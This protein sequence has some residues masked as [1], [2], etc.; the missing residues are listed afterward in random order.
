[1]TDH[2]HSSIVAFSLKIAV[3]QAG[4]HPGM[5]SNQAGV[6]GKTPTSLYSVGMH[7]ENASLLPQVP[8]FI[9][10]FHASS[11]RAVIA[12]EA[13]GLAVMRETHRNVTNPGSRNLPFTWAELHNC[14]CCCAGL[15][16][17]LINETKC[18][19]HS[20]A[21]LRTKDGHSLARS[22]FG[23]WAV[24]Q[25]IDNHRTQNPLRLENFPPIS[26]Q[27]LMLKGNTDPTGFKGVCHPLGVGRI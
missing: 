6:V 23:R 10:P 9:D 16:E 17:S 20:C 25:P 18:G 24:S 7:Y 26:A 3:K 22:L 19:C 14:S 8:E 1:M 5:S 12:T 21:R 2:N 11:E 27:L 13:F 15:S 4:D